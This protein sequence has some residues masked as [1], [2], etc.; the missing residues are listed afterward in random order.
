[1]L[2]PKENYKI[3]KTTVRVTLGFV[4][5]W[6]FLD[7]LFGLGFSTTPEKSWINGGSPTYGFLA[8]GTQG[9][10]ADVY[11]TIAGHIA[12]DWLFM[13]GLL[14]V[15]TALVLGVGVRVAGY[16]G[17]VMML[18][19]WSASLFPEQNPFID[20]HIIYALVLLWLTRTDV[21]KQFGLG[22][23]WRSLP[24]VKRRALLQ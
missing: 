11:Q 21:A 3:L 6:P 19:I 15:G 8:H 7:K 16:S 17:A 5:L 10:L 24:L 12:I 23:W 14:C 9:P 20:E 4:F 18:L 2:E 1:M 13:L 22:E